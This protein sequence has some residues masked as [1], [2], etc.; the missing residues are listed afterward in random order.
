MSGQYYEGI[1]FN[2]S[3]VISR[4]DSTI[5]SDTWSNG[6]PDASLYPDTFSVRWTGWLRPRFSGT[7]SFRS[8]SDDG[9]R[10]WVNN[11]LIIDNWTDHGETDNT[12]T[13]TL[14]AGILVPIKVEYYE[15]VGGA[16]VKLRWSSDLQAE[17]IVP[18]SQLY[19]TDQGND[20]GTGGENPGGG[21]EQEQQRQPMIYAMSAPP[22]N[23][24]VGAWINDPVHGWVAADG[25]HLGYSDF[26]APVA[27]AKEDGKDTGARI[28]DFNG[29]GRADMFGLGAGGWQFYRNTG[30]GF[31]SD[32][33]WNLPVPAA[34]V[35]YAVESGTI[36]K[37]D[38]PTFVDLNGDGRVDMIAKV[39]ITYIPFDEIHGIHRVL[40]EKIAWINTG[41][42]WD[43]VSWYYPPLDLERGSRLIDVN[44]DGL[45]DHVQHWRDQGTIIRNVALNT[46]TGWQVLTVNSAEFNRFL[47]PLLLN[48]N[49]GGSDAGVVG[50]EL[51][52]LNGDGLVDL[53]AR[54]DSGI[55][56]VPVN[57]AYFNTGNGWVL[58][59]TSFRSLNNLAENNVPQGVALLDINGDG[60]A[61]LVRSW[62]AEREV[63]LGTSE[64]WRVAASPEYNLV[65]Q[66][67]QPNLP[68]T[69]TDFVDIDA[70]GVADQIW[71]YEDVSGGSGTSK[72][73]A[74]SKVRS[75][76]RLK[77]V[78]NG[79]G[80]AASIAYAAITDRDATTGAYIVYDR[81]TD[82]LA[83]TANV[84][85]PM[86]VVKAVTHDDG[87]GGDYV[88]EYRYGGLRAH[89]VRGSL[90]F[91]WM[92]V[93]DS[94]TQITSEAQYRQDF[95]YTGMPA[96]STT[97]KSDGTV[98]SSSTITYATVNPVLIGVPVMPYA[99]QTV[100][101]SFEL[102]G[103][104]IS[105]TTTSVSD[106]DAYGNVKAMSTATTGG[107]EKI[108]TNVY[109]QDDVANWRLGRLT[110]STVVSKMGSEQVTRTS[111]FR[112]D[113]ST[114]L[115]TDEAVEPNFSG[116]GLHASASD[117]A[118]YNEYTLRT[119]YGYDP[120]G[121]KNS[122]TI[123]G[124]IYTVNDAGTT[125]STGQLDDRSTT[126]EYLD[127]RGRFPTSTSNQLGHT[128]S[129]TEY[130]QLTGALK[131]MTGANDL[132]TTWTYDVWGRKKSQQL[133]DDSDTT[134]T[135]H[136]AN[137]L[138]SGAV[139][140][141]PYSAATPLYA[142]QTTTA[143]ATPTLTYYDKFGR[144]ILVVG[145]NGNGRNVF[146]NTHYDS[147]GRAYAK[148]NP[149]FANA[150]QVNYSVTTEFDLLNRPKTIRTP[151]DD[152]PSGTDAQGRTYVESTFTYAGLK[153]TAT[154]AS[155]RKSETEKDSQGWTITST[156]NVTAA[157]SAPASS[158]TYGY[159]AAGNLR[160][161]SVT[162]DG[163]TVVLIYDQRGRKMHMTDADMGVWQYRYNAFGELIWQK[164][165][166]G[167]IVRMGYDKL[168]RM[169]TRTEPNDANTAV[170]TTTWTYDTAVGKGIGKLASLLISR[171]L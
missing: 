13:V 147:L 77:K 132:E 59:P 28:V 133:A 5:N 70:D 62:L 108:T 119:T 68:N 94:R 97:K 159:D 168:G 66:L 2:S 150:S 17:E 112:Y 48:Q 14:A 71:N 90:G 61:D 24:G 83:D 18:Q 8:T 47:P 146:V 63:H 49:D 16:T 117:A 11:H 130:D 122:V 104:L 4:V 80:V 103:S 131:K 20:G 84:I 40:G 25:T 158:V 100:Q 30:E 85:G 170:E 34:D 12:G 65:R 98:L 7:Y 27:L 91:E 32:P 163:T 38:K 31:E 69:G 64:G 124:L 166:R 79:F 75:F 167:M 78:T 141:A 53:L 116:D 99:S 10:V 165:A 102:D 118:G 88:V 121:N 23:S 56:G 145:V 160:N 139:I 41:A 149:Y 126:T 135:Y 57:T 15:S 22:A 37:C 6:T 134:I 73:A 58:A 86:Y 45:P 171:R 115:L 162:G 151:S 152:S 142:V 128:E 43:I 164:D 76:N 96:S 1:G 157:A 113:T 67:S 35:S 120:F 125:V 21:D 72:G 87:L 123:R 60:R 154:D 81:G 19:S 107:F 169:T 106:I 153:S 110:K 46:G 52:D 93:T 82:Q 3:P 39:S 143:G 140:S 109:A 44:G 36:T 161:T 95:P 42:G 92:R 114:G 105:T 156:R 138:P 9:I 89:R 26:R 50:T 127:G 136:W 137:A 51:V 74:F 144:E 54:C 148:S 55:G 129:Y 33:N 101:S 111:G 29:D 155:G